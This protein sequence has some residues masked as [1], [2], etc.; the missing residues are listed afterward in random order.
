MSPVKSATRPREILFYFPT[1][2]YVR[3]SGI[4]HLLTEQ[5]RADTAIRNFCRKN[6]IER[7]REFHGCEVDWNGSS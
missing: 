6:E 3:L 5:F 4:V 7:C 1:M 2:L